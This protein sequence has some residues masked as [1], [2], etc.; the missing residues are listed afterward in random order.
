MF[1]SRLQLGTPRDGFFKLGLLLTV[2]Q[3][4]SAVALLGVSAWLI[5]R[6][7]EVNSIV[8][9]G[10]AIVGVRG[11]AVGRAA[12]RYAERLTLHESAFRM[13]GDIRP[14]IFTKLAPFIPAGMVQASRGETMAR[15][16][17]DVDE[18][19]NLPLR[20]IAPFTQTA[21]VSLA[22]VVFVWLMLPLDG[23]ALALILIA[24]F[25]L[26]LPLSGRLSR[27]ADES[28]A[29]LK[30][31]LAAQSLDLLENQEVYVAFGWV[32]ER[33]AQL[34]ET[35]RLLRKALAKSA[36][37][38]GLGASLFSALST[39]AVLA[40]M[41]FGGKAALAGVVPG[42]ALAVFVLLPMAIFEIAQ[43]AQ[44]A[45]TEF[46]KYRVSAGRVCELLEREVPAELRFEKGNEQLP[47]FTNLELK[48]VTLAYPDTEVPAVAD[49]SLSL[50]LGE[51]VLI[52]GES[53]AGKSTIALAL[54]R[55]LALRSGEYL[56]NGRKVESFD[57][58]SRTVGLV[59]QNPMVFLGNVRANL[60]VAKPHA[61]ELEL[62]EVLE[63]VGLWQMFAAREGLDT[64]LG[65]RGVL[66]SGGEAQRLGLARAI[67][68][69]FKVL[70][71]DEPTANLDRLTGERLMVEMLTIAKGDRSV[72]LISHDRKL[73]G[74]VDREV[75][76]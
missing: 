32:Q 59:E 60:L 70:I 42:A 63:Q 48:S 31:R 15:V 12:F 36:I 1:S 73:A 6:A 53:G 37:T 44:P 43:N 52:S 34:I 30:A 54:T 46:R 14:R 68:A 7:A 27:R 75:K 21:I 40:G 33:R 11:F 10:V 16:V 23:L 41:W 65:D 4:L 28:I 20:V 47:G 9:L 61:N 55:M 67:L 25:F 13:L 72:I 71:L 19:Q 66:V 17:G 2:L 62:K 58:V 29:P 56:I 18:L 74:L 24:G 50:K 64:E 76:L 69:D 38:S 22:S 35:D 26:A 5:S 8:Y 51:T 57:S 3:G 45:V 39:M 49:F